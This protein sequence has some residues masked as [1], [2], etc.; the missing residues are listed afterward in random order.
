MEAYSLA[1][2]FVAIICVIAWSFV[3]AQLN[4]REHPEDQDQGQVVDPSIPAPTRKVTI[5]TKSRPG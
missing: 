2:L 3:S 5:R 4:H 1:F